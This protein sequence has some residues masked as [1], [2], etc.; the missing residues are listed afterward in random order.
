[1]RGNKQ[2]EPCGTRYALLAL[3]RIHKPAMMN[4]HP[5]SLVSTITSK[6][7]QLK[8]L[9]SDVIA[10]LSPEIDKVDFPAV[11]AAQAG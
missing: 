3:L 10:R 5:H 11:L 8:R 2:E 4:V 6:E 1:M 9:R 7:G